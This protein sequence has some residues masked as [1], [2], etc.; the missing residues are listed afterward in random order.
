MEFEEVLLTFFQLIF[1]SK[2]SYWIKTQ[3][4]D[5]QIIID[6]FNFWSSIVGN[7]TQLEIFPT[8]LISI[9]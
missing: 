3:L 7:C 6:I 5:C 9:A 4:Y 1:Y 2:R 8:Q